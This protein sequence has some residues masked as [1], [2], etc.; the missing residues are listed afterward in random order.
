MASDVG[1]KLGVDGERAF[2]DS[3]NAVNAQIKALGAEMTAVTATFAKNADSQQALAAKNAVLGNSIDATKSKVGV[4]TKEIASQKE[5]LDGL[6]EALEKAGREFG[7]NSKQALSAQNEYN[8]QSK[9]VSDLTAQLHRAEAELA[10]MD[11]AVEENKNKMSSWG[12]G[13][14]GAG[15][16]LKAGL[17]ATAAAATAAI[18][19][20][21]A[22]VGALAKSSLG[23]FA[24]YEQLTGGVETL[25]KE[26][27]DTVMSYADNAYK[28]AGLSANQYMETVT[29]FS[30]SL[31]QSLGGDTEKAAQTA[32]MAMTDMA[33]NA[34][35]M[36]T[37]MDSIQ[38]A[39]QG[40][41]KQNYT[42]LDN[43]KIGYGGTKEEM[44]RLLA[45]AQQLSGV[46]YDISSFSD[47]V[48]AIHV[49][50][51]EM[52]ITGTTAQEASTTIEGST[53]AMKAAWTNL[54]TG[55]A[56]E[57]GDLEGLMSSFTESVATAGSNILPRVQTILENMGAL[58]QEMVPQ[59]TAEIPAMIKQVVPPL[60]EAGGKLLGGLALGL[61]QA[62]PQLLEQAQ[63]A[64]AGLRDNFL[65]LVPTLAQGLR[66]KTPEFIS[67]GLDLLMGLSASL[68]E[69]VGM[70][71]DAALELVKSL[72]QGIADGIP[73]IIEKGPEIVSNLANTIND[74]APKILKA[75][76]DVIVTLGKGLIDAIPTL[77]ENIPKIISAIVDVWSAFNWLDLG[78]NA[79]T[80]LKNGITG[81]IS[82]V[83]SAGKNV[84]DAVVNA[85]KSLP[86]SL[87]DIGKNGLSGLVNAISSFLGA[88]KNA[89]A[90]IA[91]GILTEIKALPAKALEIGGNIVSGIVNGITAGA[92]SAINAVADLASDLLGKAK[93]ALGI[94][95]P[96]TKFREEVGQYISLGVAEGIADTSDK[97]VQAADKM[98]KDVY[99]RSKEWADRQ[100][101]YMNLSLQEQLEL[102]ETIQGQFIKGS[103]QYAQ[104]E[105]Q[106]YDLKEK[107]QAEYYN[108][109]K[110]NA[111]RQAKYQKATLREQ[112]D[113]WRGIQEQFVRES[114]QYADAEQKI[115]D[116]RGQL[117]E[118]FYQ[119]IE[120]AN[121]KAMELEKEYHDTLANRQKEIANAYGLFDKVS[122][123]EEISGQD[124]LQNLRDQVSV[125]K[126]FYSGLD[127]L[128][129]RGLGDAIVDEIRAMGPSAE[130]EL[131]ALLSLT[132]RELD[133]YANI[134]MEKQQ[135]ANRTALEELRELKK[136]TDAEISAQVDE[137]RRYY[138]QTAPDLGRSFADWLAD[139]MLSGINDVT[140]A[141][142]S[143]AKA[144][145]QPLAGLTGIEYTPPYADIAETMVS[146]G[147]GQPNNYRE[148]QEFLDWAEK[149]FAGR[150]EPITLGE[151]Q[152][153]FAG[154]LSGMEVSMD[155]RKVGRVVST[156]QEYDD[157][158]YGR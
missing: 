157:R 93:N 109:L 9:T 55:I 24:S 144:A 105:E 60:V 43:L 90:S 22:A 66:E 120:D 41:A 154:A 94:H 57:D 129:E 148:A 110:A 67:S 71:V 114:K 101:K 158:S 131:H 100:T 25:F 14:K 72:A 44:E 85:L 36:G 97:A 146:S 29:G 143:L 73:D 102:W 15:E 2:R 76:F 123:R 122:A 108:T 152:Q 40:F 52:G 130:S 117:Q 54:V 135:L 132:D 21:S 142:K 115:L 83:Q 23:A 31:L 45:D 12:D 80:F 153:A 87:A 118:E 32:D 151:L 150:S 77:V 4:L 140:S 88:A 27:S 112:L 37:A 49:V 7:E 92:A 147:G 89:M 128:S 84:L 3:I 58:I 46:K 16:K 134:Y 68:R 42:M 136:Q 28:T 30:A 121:K 79:I 34:N 59:L 26:S 137:L 35:K 116:L 39:Y 95:S 125:M 113:A 5:K 17:A 82:S 50:Q 62:A 70:L 74:N 145:M 47:I 6:G 1:V 38:N 13:W 33:D 99:T 65:Q 141:G 107:S 156:R 124:L 155:G 96:S 56:Q 133:Q 126:A 91:T 63:T 139:G 104:A 51:T 20:A 103:K 48:E 19:A 53:N 69:N 111:E 106:I 86:K 81:M 149:R 11:Q 127:K 119:K 138:S 64:L 18:T 8:K 61:T 78:K 75:A 98:A 10:N